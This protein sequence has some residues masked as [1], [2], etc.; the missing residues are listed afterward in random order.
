MRVEMINGGHISGYV[1]ICSGSDLYDGI[2]SLANT[3]PV[4]VCTGL[5]SNI[6]GFTLSSLG[7]NQV[8]GCPDIDNAQPNLPSTE[9]A[10]EIV[11]TYSISYLKSQLLGEE[12]YEEFLEDDLL[13]VFSSD[14]VDEIDQ[15]VSVFFDD[16]VD[17]SDSSSGRLRE[18]QWSAWSGRKPPRVR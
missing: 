15:T 1:D 6:A 18:Q 3:Q 11:S 4:D 10:Q 17:S 7:P 13:E 2:L 5:I 14:V 16:D 9:I 12:A 8:E